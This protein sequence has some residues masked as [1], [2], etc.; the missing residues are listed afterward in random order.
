MALIHCSFYS[1]VLGK[2][3]GAYVVLPERRDIKH[4]EKKLKT[5]FLLHGISDDY[6]KW[7]RRTPIE[8]YAKKH[9]WAVIMPDG[10]KGFYTNS[11]NGK[12][13]WDF[14]SEELPNVMVALF[15]LLS[16]KRED[17]FVAGLSMGGY[18]SMKLALLHPERFH[19]A[20]SFSGA[21]SIKEMANN[22]NHKYKAVYEKVFGT[23]GI[24]NTENDLCYMAKK[25]KEAG[26]TFPALYLSCGTKDSIYD[27]TQDF[28]K[29]L[30]DL[31]I[32]YTYEDWSGGH[33]WEFWDEAI[34]HAL[35]W[36][37]EQTK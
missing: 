10:E 9:D 12:R 4:K 35:A 7:V 1:S 27:A 23:E 3:T 19:A 6:T 26:K 18:G 25:Q 20:A 24:S 8:R 13:Y 34:Q 21:F 37:I 29:Q 11:A 36:F 28:K 14:I 32:P 2:D 15:P 22:P 5:L 31:C 17:T 33:D 16:D 30:D